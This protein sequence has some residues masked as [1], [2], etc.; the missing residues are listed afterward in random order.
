[1]GLEKSKTAAKNKQEQNSKPTYWKSELTIVDSI[2]RKLPKR[3]HQKLKISK[4]QAHQ[5]AIFK[6]G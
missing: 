5:T 2:L 3:F 1:M 4:G 6:E